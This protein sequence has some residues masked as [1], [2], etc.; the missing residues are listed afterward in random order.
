MPPLYIEKLTENMDGYGEN[1][2]INPFYLIHNFYMTTG[3]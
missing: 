3:R 2:N 1:E